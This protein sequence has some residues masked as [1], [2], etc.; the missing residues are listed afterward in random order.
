[1]APPRDEQSQLGIFFGLKDS[2]PS[3]PPPSRYDPF[4]FFGI[5][6]VA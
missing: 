3:F 5:E 1:M 2:P 6:L 4:G